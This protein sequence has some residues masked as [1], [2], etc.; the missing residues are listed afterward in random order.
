MRGSAAWM[1]VAIGSRAY[2]LAREYAL[3]RRQFG[4]PIGK[5]QLTQE[6]LVIMLGNVTAMLGNAV[7]YAELSDAGSATAAQ[8]ALVKAFNTVKLRETVALGREIFGGNGLV[9][10]YRIGRAFDDA[11]A[12][13]TFEGTRDINLLVVGKDVTGLSAFV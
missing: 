12:L 7:R 1:S 3:Q 5:Y 9:L 2:E 11:E 8:A 13:Y 6:K 10:S 4:S